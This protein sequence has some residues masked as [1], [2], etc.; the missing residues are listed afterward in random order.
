MRAFCKA[1]V[2]WT[3]KNYFSQ[4]SA[5]S[6]M[7]SNSNKMMLF[8]LLSGDAYYAPRTSGFLKLPS[9]RT[10][11]DYLQY[12]SSKPGFQS[13]IHQQLLEEA[14]ITTLPKSRRYVSLIIDEMKI[15]EGLVY[16]KHRQ[17]YWIYRPRRC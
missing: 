15:K 17:Y 16:N 1:F 2:G 7:A 5:S 13:D 14:N 3:A 11:R 12:F 9:E 8:K 10:L 6:E 4:G